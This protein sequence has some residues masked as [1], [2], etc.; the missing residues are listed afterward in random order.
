MKKR[1]VI[2]LLGILLVFAACK[3]QTIPLYDAPWFINFSNPVTDTISISFFFYPGQNQVEVAMPVKLTGF[4]PQEDIEYKIQV[5]NESTA[6]AAHFDVPSTFVYRKGMLADSAKVVVKKAA[7]LATK[8]VL[9]ILD[10]TGGDKVYAG[11][12]TH[13]RRV[14]KIN[15][16]VS[17][18]NW[19]D[20]NMER[21]YLGE[22]SEKKFRKFMEVVG[23]GDIT[24]YSAAEQ[25]AL[26]LQFKY[27][28]IEMYDAGTP[29]LMEDGRDMLSTIPLIG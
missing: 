23:V 25:R 19:W 17:K 10:I 2:H 4:M 1:Y 6:L 11:Q 29:E 15:D 8:T 14:I 3:K 18:P 26:M 24:P 5:S 27:Y 7:D 22:Y 9:L 12:T 21:F 28:L 16:M 13:L 20:A